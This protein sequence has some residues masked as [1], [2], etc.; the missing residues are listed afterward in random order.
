MVIL[1]EVTVSIPATLSVAEGDGVVSV[2][3]TLESGAI[4]STEQDFTVMLTTTDG[5]SKFLQ[6]A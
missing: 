4:E 2:C 3:V 5:S 6:Y 1:T